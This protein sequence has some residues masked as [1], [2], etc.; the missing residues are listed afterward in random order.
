MADV[1]EFDF[2][3]HRGRRLDLRGHRLRDETAMIPLTKQCGLKADQA[4]PVRK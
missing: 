4:G 3:D 1:C 2:L